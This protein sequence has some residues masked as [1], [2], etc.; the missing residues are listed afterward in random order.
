MKPQIDVLNSRVLIHSC[1]VTYALYMISRRKNTFY[2]SHSG[3]L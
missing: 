2:Y 1:L 3:E